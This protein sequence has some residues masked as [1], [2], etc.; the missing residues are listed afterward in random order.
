MNFDKI[1]LPI[2]K[3]KTNVFNLRNHVIATGEMGQLFPIRQIECVPG[4][5]FDINVE[6]FSRTAP[7]VVPTFGSVKFTT[8]AFF[9]PSRLAYP[10]FNEFITGQTVMIDNEAFDVV[11]PYITQSELIALFI[12]YSVNGFTLTERV[13]S[14]SSPHDLE[15]LDSSGANPT[16]W[17][18]TNL[19]RY[20]LKV[21]NGLGYVWNWVYRDDLEYSLLPLISMFKVYTEY[22]CPAQFV[23]TSYVT[24]FLNY[25]KT[26]VSARDYISILPNVLD[27]FRLSY[28][29]DIFMSAW[30][31]PLSALGDNEVLTISQ[32]RR[33]SSGTSSLSTVRSNSYNSVSDATQSHSNWMISMIQSL[34]NY[35]IRNNYAGPKAVNQ[36]LSRF[37]V[38]VPDMEIQRPVCFGT[39]QSSLQIMDVTNVAESETAKLGQ[40]GA[41]AIGYENGKSMHIDCKEYG[42]IL[43]MC[44]I[45]P[46]TTQGWQGVERNLFHL[47]K[48]DFFTPEFDRTMMQPVY[49]GE[50][51][52][53]Y[54]GSSYSEDDEDWQTL[55]DNN[56][57]TDNLFGFVP[58][59]SEYKVAKDNVIGD[60]RVPHLSSGLDCFHLFRE[61]FPDTSVIAQNPDLIYFNAEQ[62]NR[63]FNVTDNNQDHFYMIYR[64]RVKAV[65]PMLTIA[66]S[67]PFQ[68][69]DIEHRNTVSMK[70]NG[71]ALN[72]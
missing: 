64:I 54:K 41:K 13:A 7:L 59:Y 36:I 24:Q 57:N 65:R 31:Q 51:F 60:L 14:S 49:S 6:M 29:N 69:D 43:L 48:L 17:N 15:V 53:D 70:P 68:D 42:Y 39:Q 40:F 72:N 61:F 10:F 58:M 28:D 44:T 63:I 45:M 3:Q 18:F 26:T 35:V 62:Y 23:P 22:Y 52:N 1:K 16:Y 4:D 50:F 56:G 12:D 9:V 27:A 21:F 38:K 33:T 2:G 55:I 5:K 20:W 25:F 19:G 11:I 66:E 37:G 32:D 71:S 8:R 67:I 46:E 47:N 30:N 34:A